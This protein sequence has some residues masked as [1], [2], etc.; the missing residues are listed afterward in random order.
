MTTEETSP[1]DHLLRGIAT[2]HVETVR[3]AW[4]DLLADKAGAVPAVQAKLASHAWE[5]NP[6]DPLPRYLGVLLSLLDELDPGAFEKEI[7]RL[8]DT[9]LHPLHRTTVEMLAQRRFEQ[10]QTHIGPDIPVYVASDIADRSV[11]IHNLETWSRTATLSLTGVTRIDIIARHPQLDYLGLYNLFFSGIILTWPADRVPAQHRWWRRLDAEFTFYH[12]VGHHACGHIEGGS[13]AEQE[14]EAN[15]Y[16]RKMM[17]KAHPILS[18][19]ARA[20]LFP[21]RPLLRPLVA[22]LETAGDAL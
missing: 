7:D 8:L 13:V 3:D 14:Q 22:R 5:Y 16:A 21:F 12:E 19:I 20:L 2:D 10:P 9:Q 1:I 17:R 6:R 4:R 15:D 18:A 11:V